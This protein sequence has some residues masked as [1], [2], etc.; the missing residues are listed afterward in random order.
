VGDYFRL[1]SGGLRYAAT[2]GYYLEALQAI[3]VATAPGSDEARCGEKIE[4]PPTLARERLP[5]NC[6]DWP[7]A[8]C[9]RFLKRRSI[10]Q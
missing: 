2:T 8:D 3:P 9:M 10:K 6:W 1:L 4:K 7:E 5:V